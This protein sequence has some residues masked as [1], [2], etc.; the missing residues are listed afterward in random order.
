M[1]AFERQLGEFT[2]E[3]ISAFNSLNKL[4]FKTFHIIELL[5]LRKTNPAIKNALVE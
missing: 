5:E 3:E 4:E 2:G 1:I